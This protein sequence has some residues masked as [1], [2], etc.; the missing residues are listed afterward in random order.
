MEGGG[1]GGWGGLR[2]GEIE[3]GYGGEGRVREVEGGERWEDTAA[4]EMERE[5]SQ[6]I[7]L[8]Y[9]PSVLR[10]GLGSGC[11]LF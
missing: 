6:G 5:R 2:V 10:T 1:D 3:G 11:L 9:P 7:A 4:G 8:L